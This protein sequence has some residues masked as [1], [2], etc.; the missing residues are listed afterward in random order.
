[1][2]VS[3]RKRAESSG[4]VRARERCNGPAVHIHRGRLRKKGGGPRGQNRRLSLTSCCGAGVPLYTP[5]TRG[6]VL[7]FVSADRFVG[8]GTHTRTLRDLSRYLL[9]PKLSGLPGHGI[10]ST[11]DAARKDVSADSWS[12]RRRGAPSDEREKRRVS[13]HL[14]RFSRSF[15]TCANVNKNLNLTVH[16]NYLTLPYMFGRCA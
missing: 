9:R 8:K 12:P 1:M 4:I 10:L 15:S 5:T 6:V 2:R 14:V 11:R 16:I 3:C 13:S 7:L